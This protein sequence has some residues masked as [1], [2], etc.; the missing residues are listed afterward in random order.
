MT[1]RRSSPREERRR[2]V[3]VEERHAAGGTPRPTEGAPRSRPAVNARYTSAA[4]AEQQPRTIDLLPKRLWTLSVWFLVGL[5][6][7]VVHATLYTGY[8]R[9]HAPERQLDLSAWD[10]NGPQNLVRWSSSCM[11]LAS[12]LLAMQILQL[13]RHRVDDYRAAPIAC[14]TTSSSGCC[15]QAW[16]RRRAYIGSWRAVPDGSCDSFDFAA[17]CIESPLDAPRRRNSFGN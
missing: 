9:W 5:C 15:S 7:V 4:R 3:L 8:L 17:A 14:G 12:A 2:R 16:I 10:L 11:L 1:V 13:R 6:V